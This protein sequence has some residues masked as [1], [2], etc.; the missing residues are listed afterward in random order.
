MMSIPLAETLTALVESIEPP[1]GSGLAIERASLEVPIEARLEPTPRG[2][3]LVGSLPHTRWQSGL[4]P[5]VHR[6]QL[7][8]APPEDEG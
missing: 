2:L 8:L 4:L 5:A 3:V 7:E 6:V 1:P